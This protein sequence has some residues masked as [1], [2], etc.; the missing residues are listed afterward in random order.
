MDGFFGDFGWVDDAGFL[1]IDDSLLRIHDVD[2][3]TRLGFFDFSKE[4][5]RIEAGVFHDMN[6][7]SGESFFNNGGA[8]V[9]GFEVRC[10]IDESDA[11]SGHDTFGESSLSSGDSVINAVFL[12][13]DFGFGSAADFDDGDFAKES[14]SAFFELAASVVGVLEFGLRLDEFDAVFD[15]FL[16]ASAFDDG[17]FI[18]G[19]DDFT[20]STENFEA[21]FFEF[22]AAIARY[23]GSVSEDGDIFHDFFAAVT[24]S[25]S[26]EDES[27]E[28]AF[29]FVEDEDRESFAFDFFGNDN[30]IFAAGLST[31]LEDRKKFL[32]AADF[33]VGDKNERLIENSFLAISVGDEER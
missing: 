10:E 15:G 16:V 19:S 14:S 7:R 13:V 23:D 17:S 11:T 12:F 22:H 24:E 5:L 29:E 28:D 9:V 21:D 20:A 26:F 3:E 4:S 25:R 8:V 1:Q 6:K 18:F 32:G 33:L 27:V 31:L 2:T 30:E